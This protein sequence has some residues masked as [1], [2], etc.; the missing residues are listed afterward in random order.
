MGIEN[1]RHSLKLLGY[2]DN[3]LYNVFLREKNTWMSGTMP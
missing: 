2:G 1:R 3:Y